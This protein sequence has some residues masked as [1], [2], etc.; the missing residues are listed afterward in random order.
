LTFKAGSNKFGSMATVAKGKDIAKAVQ[1]PR[2]NAK[3][4]V[5]IAAD[6]FRE[7]FPEAAK[8]NMMLEEIEE[9][10]D[11]KQWLITLGYDTAASLRHILQSGQARAYKRLTIDQAS[12]R[13]ISARI[14]SLD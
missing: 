5:A 14:R 2:L 9:S 12:G 6:Y 1:S 13:V 10:Q 7:L 11:G 3:Q 4:A 8:A